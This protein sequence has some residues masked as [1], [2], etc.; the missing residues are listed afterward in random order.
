MYVYA[1]FFKWAIPGLFPFIFVFSNKQ[2][3]FY[4]KFMWK[5]EFIAGIQTHYIQYIN[6]LP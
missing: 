6:L 1:Y 3:N 5:T 2:Y 4:N